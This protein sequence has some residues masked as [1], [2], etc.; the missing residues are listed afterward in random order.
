VAAGSGR[1]LGVIHEEA[2]DTQALV[3][4]VRRLSHRLRGSLLETLAPA[5]ETGSL[6]GGRR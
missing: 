2:A 6:V 4:T 1:L 5:A 3:P